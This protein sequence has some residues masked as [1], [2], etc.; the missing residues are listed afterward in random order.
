MQAWQQTAGM[1]RERWRIEKRP[2]EVDTWLVV[3]FAGLNRE[4]EF[5]ECKS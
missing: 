3:I 4:T 5:H 2:D 1:W